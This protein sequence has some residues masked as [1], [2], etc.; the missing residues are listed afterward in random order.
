MTTVTTDSGGSSRRVYS[1][2]FLLVSVSVVFLISCVWVSYKKPF[3]LDEL[4]CFYLA[5]DPSFGHMIHALAGGADV[6][7]PP[8]YVSLWT[9]ARVGGVSEVSLRLHS[10]LWLSV[11]FA[12]IWGVLRR[13]YGYWPASAGCLA[14][15]CLSRLVLYQN[16]EARFYGFFL[17]VVAFGIW[18]YDRVY[19]SNR[20][21]LGQMTLIALANA[22]LILS[23]IYGGFYSG[24]ILL[25]WMLADF[26]QCRW[27]PGAYASVVIGW[28]AFLP[29][30]PIFRHQAAIFG[31]ESWIPVPSIND[32]LDS[33]TH[34]V[35]LPLALILIIG[36]ALLTRRRSTIESPRPES[37]PQEALF[38]LAVILIVFVPIVGWIFSRLVK[39]VFWDRYMIPSTLGWAIV[40]TFVSE[41]VGLGP[42]YSTAPSPRTLGLPLLLA[43]FLAFPILYAWAHPTEPRPT[44]ERLPAALAGLPVVLDTPHAFLPRVH[45]LGTNSNYYFILDWEAATD[46][47]S[48]RG[49]SVN[50]KIIDLLHEYYSLPNAVSTQDFLSRYPRFLYF[51][52]YVSAWFDLRVRRSGRYKLTHI[53]RNTP[54][55]FLADDGSI[56]VWLAERLA[57][58]LTDSRS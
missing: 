5:Q 43:T 57:P 49:A 35:N 17:A 16:T 10:W 11:A 19:E 9:W 32:L 55:L 36:F 31:Y 58:A 47:K 6:V 27:R 24:A 41:R 28:L 20:L 42:D 46:P 2:R 7:P 8:Y 50:Y 4:N 56:D 23:H 30:L 34:K 21:R 26:W 18:V 14:A 37:P 51:D 25:A 15:F 39:S 38:V 45:Y 22:L 1:Q 48:Q 29:W 3:W 12:L 33:F 53:P 52:Q 54:G 40:L 44:A 13:R